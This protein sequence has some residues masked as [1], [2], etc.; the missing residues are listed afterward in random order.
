[1]NTLVNRVQLVGRLGA[2]P[3]IIQL[4]GDKRLAKFSLAVNERYLT[5]NGE[6]KE[7]TEWFNLIA[8]DKKAE[9]VERLL[10]KGAKV[11]VGGS[12][13]TNKWKDKEGNERSN[14]QISL[15]DFTVLVKSDET[16]TK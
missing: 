11:A 14:L 2:N 10:I 1:M 15:N 3:E 4:E 16:L 12:L 6:R 7:R 8:W 9:L 5:K 13:S